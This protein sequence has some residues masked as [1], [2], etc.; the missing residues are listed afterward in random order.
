MLSDRI[1]WTSPAQVELARTEIMDQFEA[2]RSA[3]SAIDNNSYLGLYAEDFQS[4]DMQLGDWVAY[5]TRVNGQKSW[6]DVQASDIAIY[7]Y[8]GKSDMLVTEYHQDYRSSNFN[9]QGRKQLFWK[10][11]IDGSWKIVYEGAG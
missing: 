2:W 9:A 10:R 3:W 4:P 6:I 5:K 7:H 8:P 11:Q 1:R